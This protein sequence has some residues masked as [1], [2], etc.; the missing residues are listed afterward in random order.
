M[1]ITFIYMSEN[2]LN[3]Y[4]STMQRQILELAANT[5]RQIQSQQITRFVDNRNRLIQKRY[6]GKCAAWKTRIDSKLN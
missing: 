1:H 4:F 5:A 3:R 2:K 6:I